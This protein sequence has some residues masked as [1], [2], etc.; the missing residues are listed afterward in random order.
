MICNGQEI[1]GAAPTATPALSPLMEALARGGLRD[2]RAGLDSQP[3]RAYYA[4]DADHNHH[5][6]G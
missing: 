6:G 5:R 2:R 4:D 3:R 1:P